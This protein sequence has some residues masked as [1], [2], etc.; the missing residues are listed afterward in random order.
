M[1]RAPFVVVLTALALCAL[2]T[3]APGQKPA[4]TVAMVIDGTGLDSQVLT[5]LLQE[6]I[7]AV[8]AAEFDA[9]VLAGDHYRGDETLAGVTAALDRALANPDVDLVVTTGVLG[10]LVAGQRT[11]LPRP[12]IAAVALNTAVQGLPLTD[13]GTSGRQSFTYVIDED[14]FATDV[15]ALQA[16]AGPM[17]RVALVGTES[18]LL[19]LP[20]IGAGDSY[21]LPGG[22][23]GD[24]VVAG[25]DPAAAVAALPSD[26]DG[27]ILLGLAGYSLA[28]TRELIDALNARQLPTLSVVGEVAVELGVLVGTTSKSTLQ[29]LSRRVALNARKILTGTEAAELPVRLPREP[30]LF[31]NAETARRIAVYPP[32]SVTVDAVLIDSERETGRAIDLWQVMDDAMLAN[33]DLVAAAARLNADRESIAIARSSLLPQV[34]LSA[35]GMLLD[36]DRALAGSRPAEQSITAGATLTQVL[37]SDDA[38]SAYTVQKRLFAQ[39]EAEFEQARLDVA[40][41]ASSA[42]FEVLRAKTRE[43]LQKANLTLSRENLDRARVRVKLG[44]ASRAEEYRWQAK[45]AEEKANLIAAIAERNVA[46]ME[47]NRV[48]N[49]PLE[50]SIILREPDLDGQLSLLLDPRLER[51]LGDA[52]HLEKLREFGAD[53]ARRVAPELLQLEAGILAQE[54]ILAGARRSF[55]VPDVLL[56]LGWQTYLHEGGAGSENRPDGFPDDNDWNA[57]L[58]VS[59]PLFEGGQ[60]F[61]ETNQASEDLLALRLQREATGER[62]EQRVRTAVHRTSAS[63]AGIGLSQE[64]AEAA[65][66]NLEL[67]SDAYSRGAVD[68]ITVL[69]AQ[70]SQLSADLAAADA[71]YQ[72]LLDLMELERSIG[73]FTHFA[74]PEERDA[75]L[76]DLETWFAGQ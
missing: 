76:T 22:V 14:L 1:P 35:T 65:R 13:A 51:F 9:T 58:S 59:L 57:S 47:L 61:A 6:E 36:E 20:G 25:D 37:V 8:L 17:Q 4:A 56:S 69:D 31:I 71:A 72:F 7:A 41:R 64:A 32:F 30:A 44:D 29:R 54:R 74:T 70:N 38:W 16:V 62:I 45:I 27:V 52:W 23:I 10:S 42:Y 18:L 50:E 53:F 60:R 63:R 19:A 46:E 75:W 3:S 73:R 39:R 26:L 28:Q 49:R 34:D 2:T 55:L 48:L 15:A 66:R 68:L 12:V 5:D 43:R 21:E 40:L 11:S 33:R 67:V 24:L